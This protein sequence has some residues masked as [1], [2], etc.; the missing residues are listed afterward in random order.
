LA[1]A[2]S[3]SSSSDVENGTI[4]SASRSLD[5]GSGDGGSK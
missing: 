4:A 5:E 2:I 1:Q 3:Y